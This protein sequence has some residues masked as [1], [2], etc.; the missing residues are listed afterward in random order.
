MYALGPAHPPAGWH[1]RDVVG[2]GGTDAVPARPARR[3]GLV[4]GGS[5]RRPFPPPRL[6]RILF[7]L[8]PRGPAVPPRHPGWSTVHPAPPENP[9]QGRLTSPVVEPGGWT[10]RRGASGAVGCGGRRDGAHQRYGQRGRGG[11]GQRRR[12]SPRWRR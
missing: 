7:N 10:A 9:L 12:P 3:T 2:V 6:G 8:P 1:H 11:T 5:G 4:V